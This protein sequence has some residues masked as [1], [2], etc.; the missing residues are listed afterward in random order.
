MGHGSLP[1]NKRGSAPLMSGLLPQEGRDEKNVFT[2]SA[3]KHATFKLV[4]EYDSQLL[5]VNILDYVNL[6]IKGWW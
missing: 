1:F 5:Y 3:Q 6:E 2:L 4:L